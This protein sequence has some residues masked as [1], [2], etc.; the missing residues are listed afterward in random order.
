MTTFWE[1][2]ELSW[3]AEVSCLFCYEMLSQGIISQSDNTTIGLSSLEIDRR[4]PVS[5]EFRERI[6]RRNVYLLQK[7]RQ[8]FPATTDLVLS[9]KYRD[10]IIGK[11]A[12]VSSS[13]AL[14]I[15]LSRRIIRWSRQS[16]QIEKWECSP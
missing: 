5:Q 14:Y 15:Q 9:A 13:L 8:M 10:Y 3:M 11:L 7:Q 2:R 16:S 6:A 4:T 12:L 1:G